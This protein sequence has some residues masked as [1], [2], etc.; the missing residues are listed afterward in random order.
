MPIWMLHNAQE[1]HE[2]IWH[3]YNALNV[4]NLL[5]D[6]VHSRH[7]ISRVKVYTG[8]KWTDA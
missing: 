3:Q 7:S 8:D 5:G 4:K 2:V 1:K 6:G